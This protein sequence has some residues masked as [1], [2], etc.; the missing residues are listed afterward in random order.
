MPISYRVLT[1]HYHDK[2]VSLKVFNF[3]KLD[4]PMCSLSFSEKRTLAFSFYLMNRILMRERFFFFSLF[5][6]FF[7]GGGASGT[8]FFMY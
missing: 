2:D 5:F 4:S 6:F 7:G 3:I 8:F 1:P